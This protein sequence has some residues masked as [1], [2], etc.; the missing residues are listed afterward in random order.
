[1]PGIVAHV[2]SPSLLKAKWEDHLK[3]GVGL[4][5]TVRLCLR[6]NPKE[7]GKSI[8]VEIPFLPPPVC[9]LLIFLCGT[10]HLLTHY[11]THLHIVSAVCSTVD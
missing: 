8:K 6:K 5:N 11:R 4:S 9:P 2:C 3:P 7:K 1:M 10:C